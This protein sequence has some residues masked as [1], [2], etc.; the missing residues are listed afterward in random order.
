MQLDLA[1]QSHTLANDAKGHAQLLKL[2]RAH[3]TGQ[4]VCEAT[5]GHEQPVVRVLHA[6]TVPVSVVEAGRGRHFARAKGQRAKTDP[7][8]AAVLSEYGAGLPARAHGRA[9]GPASPPG[10]LAQVIGFTFVRAEV[11]RCYGHNGNEGVD[12]IILAKLMFL[13]FFDDVPSERELM[14]RLP[15]R[16][17]SLWFLG[18]NL[19]E[20]TPHHRVLSKARARRGREAFENIFLRTVQPCVEAG[21]VDGK[22]IQVDSSLIG[23]HAS[24]DPVVTS[25]PELIAA[26]KK[27]VAAPAT[28]LDDTMTPEHD[29]AVNDTHLSTTDP[30]AALVRQ[31]GR[32]SA[33]PRSHHHRA[34]DAAHGV[35]TAVETT[36]GS[37]AENKKLSALLQPHEAHTEKQADTVAGDRQYGTNE[38]LAACVAAE[39]RPHLG[40]LEDKQKK[41]AGRAGLCAEK[42]FACDEKSDTHRCPAGQ[43]LKRRRAC[44]RRHTVEYAPAAGVCGKCPLREHCT[45]AAAGRTVQ[46]HEQA[47]LVAGKAIARSPQARR[48]RRRRRTPW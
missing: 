45:T 38:N 10:R 43:E 31:G 15:E 46:R 25:G 44:A 48:D 19:D 39:I 34:V 3:P 16:L 2:L 40:V 47:A 7:V 22:K 23:A 21:L 42:D 37:L 35:I 6:S 24:K 29:E 5:G 14:E 20:T 36:P 41:P 1:G 12:P 33:R 13:L 9:D 28:K 30:D 32:R 8:D 27:A 11:A 17:D 4:I 18:C 26:C